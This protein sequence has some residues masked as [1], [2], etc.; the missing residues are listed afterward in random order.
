MRKSNTG[1]LPSLISSCIIATHVIWLVLSAALWHRIPSRWFV[2]RL[3]GERLETVWRSLTDSPQR[4][5]SQKSTWPLALCLYFATLRP[6]NN[7]QLSYSE[8]IRCQ[9]A[10]AINLAIAQAKWKITVTSAWR[11][12]EEVTEKNSR[13][14]YSPN[15][16]TCDLRVTLVFFSFFYRLL[17]AFPLT[18]D[19]NSFK[20]RNWGLF[21][22]R[23]LIRGQIRVFHSNSAIYATFAS[24]IAFQQTDELSS[25][26]ELK[27]ALI[28]AAGRSPGMR[29]LIESSR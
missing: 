27:S 1:T 8:T 17:S 15:P 2:V 23:T 6:M 14:Y 12:D 3:N 5:G 18:S 26:S 10:G 4:Q 25:D 22:V 11:N 13:F 24:L 7:H 9:V 16:K 28:E 29:S 20:S 21:H 19:L